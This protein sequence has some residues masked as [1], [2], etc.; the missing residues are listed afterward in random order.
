MI[1]IS[2][3]LKKTERNFKEKYILICNYSS[4]LQAANINSSAINRELDE[5]LKHFSR[6]L[7]IEANMQAFQKL[8]K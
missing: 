4:H 3:N 1:I 5:L 7:E 2:T 8:S 6:V